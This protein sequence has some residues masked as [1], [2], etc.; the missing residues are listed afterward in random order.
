MQAAEGRMDAQTAQPAR[1]ATV[2]KSAHL[3]R[4]HVSHIRSALS[5]YRLI[6]AATSLT[7]THRPQYTMATVSSRSSGLLIHMSNA[8]RS[9]RRAVVRVTCELGDVR[10]VRAL[11]AAVLELVALRHERS[12]RSR[13]QHADCGGG[14][15][16]GEED[17]REQSPLYRACRGTRSGSQT[18]RSPP[19]RWASLA[20]VERGSEDR[21]TIN[22]GRSVERLIES[23]MGRLSGR[24]DR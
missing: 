13:R 3:D 16:L 19:L 7:T 2:E 6:D 10:M 4:H 18:A 24:S 17:Q 14:S 21:D 9:S 11:E 8:A 1:T 12:H 5:H 15:M 23:V 22:H 20:E